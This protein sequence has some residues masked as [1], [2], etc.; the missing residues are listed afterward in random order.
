M[1]YR[2]EVTPELVAL[3]Q[4]ELQDVV[5]VRDGWIDTEEIGRGLTAVLQKV[6]ADLNLPCDQFINW[7][8][9]WK[10]EGTRKEPCIERGP[11]KVHQTDNGVKW[12]AHED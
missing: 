3:F 1:T 9:I 5:V 4:Q 7:S 12:W 8:E 6:Q 10:E 11:H 2:I